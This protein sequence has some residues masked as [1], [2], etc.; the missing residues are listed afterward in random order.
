MVLYSAISSPLDR[1][2]R[3]TLGL[4][5]QWYKVQ[6]NHACTGL[7]LQILDTIDLFRGACAVKGNVQVAGHVKRVNHGAVFYA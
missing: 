2:K 5:S 7:Q 1:S 6:P 4:C 3:F